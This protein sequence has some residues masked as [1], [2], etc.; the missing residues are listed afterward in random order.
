MKGKPITELF[1]QLWRYQGK[2]SISTFPPH[3]TMPMF[4]ILGSICLS[5]SDMAAATVAPAAASITSW[6]INKISDN[7]A[8]TIVN[9]Q[10]GFTLITMTITQNV[11]KD[12]HFLMFTPKTC[13]QMA[14]VVGSFLSSDFHLLICFPDALDSIKLCLLALSL[15]SS[16][17][18]NNRQSR[19]LSKTVVINEIKQYLS[20]K[21]N[22]L[23]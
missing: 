7:F 1:Y 4:F 8:T 20:M 13:H 11:S 23:K 15:R 14:S 19:P 2:L 22:L 10:P 21:A 17:S 16:L 6:K 18:N 9:L 5:F 12:L 3:T